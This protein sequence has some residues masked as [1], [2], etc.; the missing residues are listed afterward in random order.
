MPTYSHFSARVR[1]M[2]QAEKEE[3]NTAIAREMRRTRLKDEDGRLK[4]AGYDPMK[5]FKHL[6]GDKEAEAKALKECEE[7]AKKYTD[8]TGVELVVAPGFFF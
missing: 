6:D 1:Y 2:T 8:L 7:Y 5:V 4:E 3:R